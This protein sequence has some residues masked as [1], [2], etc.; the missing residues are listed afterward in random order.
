VY[1]ATAVCIVSLLHDMKITTLGRA[2]ASAPQYRRYR[3]SHID[4]EGRV[5]I[6]DQADHP[7]SIR[8]VLE[9]V[10]SQYPD[11][12]IWCLYQPGSYLRTKAMFHE[13]QDALRLADFVYLSDIKGYP[14]EK[15]EGLNI[16]HLISEMKRTH[17]QT[18]YFDDTMDM[19]GLLSDRVASTDCV[20]V[21]G[22]EGLCQTILQSLFI[23]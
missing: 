20:V 1:S 3:E 16:R 5:I 8:M 13:I 6:D 10:K 11:K 14:K 18:Y 2:L 21:L 22:A 9:S 19:S 7:E 4:K 23:N 12:K 17:P 15:S